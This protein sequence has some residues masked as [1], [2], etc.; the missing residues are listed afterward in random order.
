MN[1]R[2]LSP[3]LEII[4][5]IPLLMAF[6]FIPQRLPRLLVSGAM[7]YRLLAMLFRWIIVKS[8]DI[9]LESREH[10]A[11]LHRPF[12]LELTLKNRS[13]LPIPPFT[14]E[15][16]A[17]GLIFLNSNI[18]LVSLNG[19]GTKTLSF[20]LVGDRRGVYDW[21]PFTL[22]GND[23]LQ[24]F[25]WKKQLK[26]DQ[27]VVLYPQSFSLNLAISRGLTGGSIPVHNRIFENMTS[28]QALRKYQSGDEL[29]RINWKA[30][31]RMGELYSNI[32]DCSLYF[33]VQLI[34]NLSEAE[35]PLAHRYEL[36]EKAVET[37]ASLALH[38]LEIKQSVSM[39]SSGRHMKDSR[40]YCWIPPG[41]DQEHSAAILD[42]LAGIQGNPKGINL[43][44]L[45]QRPESQGP[46]GTKY[47][48]I[49]P[50]PLQEEL[51]YIQ[52]QHRM[53]KDIE[54]F[55]I[56]GYQAHRRGLSIPG[57]PC[58][59]VQPNQRGAQREF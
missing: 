34:L 57:I 6:L 53:G 47:I 52:Q 7:C 10:F 39:L 27:Q 50:P 37:T 2:R 3:F 16:R 44:E 12:T 14:L 58:Y 41:L 38:Y 33:P 31:A 11:S 42:Q 17:S 36:L 28:F 8:I 51:I 45:F 21:G 55:I 56:S 35:Y 20:S 5:F 18:Q 26:M 43:K 4:I 30:S 48:L 19:L 22:R 29:K 1:G 24:L 46:H 54:L 23:P 32:Y 49:T 13:L 40:N 15:A 25:Q 9:N 59:I